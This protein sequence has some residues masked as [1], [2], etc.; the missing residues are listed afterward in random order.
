[1][2]T[3]AGAEQQRAGPPEAPPDWR[4]RR[5]RSASRPRESA[6]EGIRRLRGFG[7]TAIRG[8]PLH[9][10][11]TFIVSKLGGGAQRLH[12][13]LLVFLFLFLSLHRNLLISARLPLAAN[14]GRL[15]A[16]AS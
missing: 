2:R 9:R 4:P 10:H 12:L 14:G 11:A 16:H 1:M 13:L 3:R 6:R 15:E 8:P 5:A 7:P